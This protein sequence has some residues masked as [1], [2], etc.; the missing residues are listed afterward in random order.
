MTIPQ[1]DDFPAIAQAVREGINDAYRLGIGQAVR[2]LEND[3]AM[4]WNDRELAVL[5]WCIHRLRD[6]ALLAAGQR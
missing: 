5:D 3:K 6:L 1:E 4:A 2:A